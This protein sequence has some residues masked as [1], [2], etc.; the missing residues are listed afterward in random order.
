MLPWQAEEVE[1]GGRCDAALLDE[2]AVVVEDWGVDPS[3]VYAEAR[4]PDD[5]SDVDGRA[6]GERDAGAGRGGSASVK[7]DA[8]LSSTSGA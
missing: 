8:K 2:A 3:V 5:G 1:A 4:C 7:P 6:V